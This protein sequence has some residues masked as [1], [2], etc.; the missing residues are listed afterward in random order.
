MEK[1]EK[2]LYLHTNANVHI[3]P[4]Y[5]FIIH[6]Y[7]ATKKLGKSMKYDIADENFKH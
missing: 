6:K 7:L 5:E 1:S 4:V 2:V 3:Y